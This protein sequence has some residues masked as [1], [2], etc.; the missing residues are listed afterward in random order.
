MKRILA[1]LLLGP[2]MAWAWQPPAGRPVTATVGFA[3]GSGNEVSFRI[4]AAQVERA[5]PKMTFVV[6]NKP[7]AGEI[8]GV[9]WFAQQ[10]P[11]GLNL[12]Y[13]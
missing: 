4:V 11:N 6:Q 7:G 9:N 5:N 2:A 12:V 10:Q 8:V 13:C 1:A 3:P